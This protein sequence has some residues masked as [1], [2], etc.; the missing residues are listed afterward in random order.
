MLDLYKC[1]VSYCVRFCVVLSTLTQV[2][3]CFLWS[4]WFALI[5][6]ECN[7]WSKSIFHNLCPA[8]LTLRGF[9]PLSKF[10]VF[11]VIS[12]CMFPVRKMPLQPKSFLKQSAIDVLKV[13]HHLC[14]LS[15]CLCVVLNVWNDVSSCQRLEGR[16]I[17]CLLISSFHLLWC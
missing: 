7:W 1:T 3:P 8:P 14:D 17:C 13:K 11:P 16:V 10:L 9:W 15:I 2:P 6:Q 4:Q 5:T 12:Y